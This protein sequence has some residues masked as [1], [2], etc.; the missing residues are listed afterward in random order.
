MPYL[1]QL[2]P[3]RFD[4]G[5]LLTILD[6]TPAYRSR[7]RRLAAGDEYTPLGW[8]LLTA[9]AAHPKPPSRVRSRLRQLVLNRRHGAQ[10][11]GGLSYLDPDWVIRH[12]GE[13]VQGGHYRPRVILV[14]LHNASQRERFSRALAKQPLR[15]RRR[16]LAAI[17]ERVTSPAER[18][19][20]RRLL[21]PAV[22]A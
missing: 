9:M 6:S 10:I 8:Q 4:P 20:L 11:L 19:R 5:R 12:A 14:N 22:V 18:K 16:A 17:D 15:M 2:Y 13:V 21:E 3:E 7:R 1:P